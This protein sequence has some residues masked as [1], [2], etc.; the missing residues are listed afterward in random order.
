M[1]DTTTVNIFIQLLAMSALTTAAV[2]AAAPD[3]MPAWDRQAQ[4]HGQAITM[5]PGLE[6]AGITGWVFPAQG[7]RPKAVLVCLHGIQTHSSWFAPLAAELTPQGIT[8]ACPDRRGSGMHP[9]NI[10]QTARRPAGGWEV[11]IGDV[12]AVVRSAR[13]LG[14]PVYVLGTSWGAKPA[15]GLLSQPG[16]QPDGTLLLLPAIKTKKENFKAFLSTL[17]SGLIHWRSG[18]RLPLEDAD[19]LPGGAA[20]TAPSNRWLLDEMEDDGKLKRRATIGFQFAAKAMQKAGLRH[21]ARTAT[22]QDRPRIVTI[23]AE[24]GDDQIVDGE[25]SRDKLTNLAALPVLTLPPNSGHGAQ[26]LNPSAVARA[27]VAG[28]QRLNTP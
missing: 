14:A 19:Y 21:L 28:I 9:D 17:G 11:W 13:T 3:R 26:V 24:Q 1:N 15:L 4:K 23:F 2:N 5:L 6:Q 22:G 7:T 10:S 18:A 25:A 27:V 20:S 16:S 8:L 12:A